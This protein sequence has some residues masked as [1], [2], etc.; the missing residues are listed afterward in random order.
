MPG[1]REEFI[2]FVLAVLSGAIVRLVYKCISSFREIVRHSL[3]AIGA[4]DFLFWLGS[5][6][7]LFVQ[8]YHT[9]DGSIRWY[10]ILGVVLGAVL[11]AFL[12]RQAEK[13]HK[14]MYARSKKNSSKTIDKSGKKR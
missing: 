13:I 2:V 3:A 5:A 8:I 7:Y 14:K 12:I 1:I 6:L 9:S 4:E 11:A 10:F